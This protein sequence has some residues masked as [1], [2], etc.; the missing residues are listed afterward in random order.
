LRSRA[1]H[2]LASLALAFA[3]LGFTESKNYKLMEISF[4]QLTTTPLTRTLPLLVEKAYEADMRVLV[5]ADKT[6]IKELDETL[7][8]AYQQKFLPH[9]TTNP[10]VQP[11]FITD[12]LANDGRQV[13]VITNGA[14]Y[15]G[16]QGYN[17]ILDIFDGNV[18]SELNS[19]RSRWKAYKEKGYELKYWYQDD[20]GKWLQ[21]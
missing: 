2:S 8:T 5:L 6:R 4:Y 12:N 13:L 19:A 16:T 21:K 18:E 17:K 15:D 14:N 1:A 7:W 20:K 11:I 3:A 9:G 10:E